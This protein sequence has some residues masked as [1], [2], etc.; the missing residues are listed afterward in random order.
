MLS[1]E[2]HCLVTHCNM[3]NYISKELLT[4]ERSLQSV[5]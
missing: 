5:E 3:E 4:V 1:N 2:R